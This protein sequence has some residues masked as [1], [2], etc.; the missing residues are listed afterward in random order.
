MLTPWG[1]RS[2]SSFPA[3]DTRYGKDAGHPGLWRETGR[4]QA[5]S[6]RRAAPWTARPHIIGPLLN[7]CSSLRGLSLPNETCASVVTGRFCAAGESVD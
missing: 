4:A 6:R 7:L 2:V 3:M 5:G 1:Q